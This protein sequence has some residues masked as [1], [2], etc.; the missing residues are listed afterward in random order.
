[1][2]GRLF[3][4]RFPFFFCFFFCFCPGLFMSFHFPPLLLM[5]PPLC[6]SFSLFFPPHMTDVVVF[7]YLAAVGWWPSELDGSVRCSKR[8]KSFLLPQARR[9]GGQRRASFH[10]CHQQGQ[11]RNRRKMEKLSETFRLQRLIQPCRTHTVVSDNASGIRSLDAIRNRDCGLLPVL[12]S[13]QLVDSEPKKV[14]NKKW[15]R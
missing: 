13:C 8:N 4:S 5:L 14:V 15:C 1:M 6:V 12:I 7:L 3:P 9:C 2:I 10:H 11:Q